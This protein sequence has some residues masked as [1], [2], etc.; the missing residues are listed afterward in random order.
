MVRPFIRM[1]ASITP[2]ICSNRFFRHYSPYLWYS[3]NVR[4]YRI[5]RCVFFFFL[6]FFLSSFLSFFSF[7]D[8]VLMLIYVIPVWFPFPCPGVDNEDIPSSLMNQGGSTCT[9]GAH[10]G[11]G[12][13]LQNLAIASPTPLDHNRWPWPRGN[14]ACLGRLSQNNVSLHYGLFKW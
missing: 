14:E 2:R 13:S 5:L 12:L 4:M 3:S 1:F 7:V 11:N 8:W 10:W 9:R 6:S